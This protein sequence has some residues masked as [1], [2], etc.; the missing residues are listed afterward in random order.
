M[1]R[2]GLTL[3]FLVFVSACGGQEAAHVEAGAAEGAPCA[4]SGDCAGVLVCGWANDAMPHCGER[5]ACVRPGCYGDGG[6][7]T[8][9]GG[10]VTCGCDGNPVDEVVLTTTADGHGGV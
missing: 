8:L 2:I 6:N 5:G 10:F 9:W 1:E 4:A 7:C 3:A